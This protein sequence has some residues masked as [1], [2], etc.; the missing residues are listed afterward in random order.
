MKNNIIFFAVLL[1]FCCSIPL[2]SAHASVEQP[3]MRVKLVNYVKNTTQLTVAFNG[4][5]TL[6]ETFFIPSGKTYQMRIV[7]NELGL[8]DGT[9][10]VFRGE[11]IS[12]V[13]AQY[14]EAHLIRINNRPYLGTIEFQI[15]NA[16][17]RPM[18]T[19]PLEDYVKGVVPAEMPASWHLEALKAQA[20]AA[21]TYAR[22]H[23]RSIIDDTISFQVYG[24]Y[25]WHPNSTKAV[26]DTTGQT[27]TFNN[28]LIDAVY[29]S[30]NGGMTESNANVWNGTSLPYFPI[31]QDSFDSIDPW[32]FTLAKTQIDISNL[33]V[34][35]PELWW[36]STREVDTTIPA[37]IKTWLLTNGYSNQDIKLVSIPFLHLTNPG[38]GGRVRNGAIKVDFFLRDRG[39][40][41]FSKNSDGTM[42]LHTVHFTNTSAQRIRAMIGINHIRSYLIDEVT[43]QNNRITVR[44]RGWGH[45]VGLSQYGAK[46]RADAGHS[47]VQI[48]GFYYPH[49]VLTP[50]LQYNQP[51]MG[52]HPPVQSIEETVTVPEVLPLEITNVQVDFNPNT[53]QMIIRYRLNQDAQMTISIQDSTKRT[54]A[55]LIRDMTRSAG[56]R[57]QYW[58]VTNI[59]NGNYTFTI[60]AKAGSQNRIATIEQ[61]LQRTTTPP[62]QEPTPVV[63][64]PTNPIIAPVPVQPVASPP[65]QEQAVA[66]VGTQ[67]TG[68]INVAVANIRKNASTSSSI[69]GKARRNDTV[70]ITGRQGEFYRIRAGK[71]RGFIHTS[72]ITIN[73]T[74]SSKD[75]KTTLIVNGKVATLSREPIRRNKTIYVPIKQASEQ[76]GYKYSWNKST[77]RLTI[78]N[79]TDTVSMRVNQKQATVNQRNRTLTNQ[80]EILD[81]NVFVSLRTLR[82]TTMA[83]THWDSKANVIWITK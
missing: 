81:S 37:N 68:K 29:S 76:I 79:R 62:E 8:F 70:Q 51:V 50:K 24:G 25:A 71:I 16:F 59:P 57:A 77:N 35:K 54:I 1:L 36:D 55:T 80:P 31:Q 34:M 27:L 19:I 61:A 45:G 12:F 41:E 65:K 40:R 60:E 21:R 7:N 20:V 64:V 4:N 46:N 9:H 48:L 33:D 56:D 38:T 13:P 11:R 67:I 44:G 22:K 75:R 47:Y 52:N 83:G 63:T 3:L 5:Y 2:P 78:T 82:E 72:L 17:I 28:A 18:N 14:N 49:T 26:V 10:Q 73:E 74:I 42:K 66:I 30:S 53:E 6:N 58:T 15:E 69:I 43:D 32:N 23:Q 39:T